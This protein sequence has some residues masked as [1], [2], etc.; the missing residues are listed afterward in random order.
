ML[1][2]AQMILAVS[3]FSIALAAISK[4]RVGVRVAVDATYCAGM[5]RLTT[6]L[7]LS[8]LPLLPTLAITNPANHSRGKE[9]QVVT[10]GSQHQQLDRHPAG[11]ERQSITSRMQ[12]SQ[13]LDLDRQDK[14]QIQREVVGLVAC[15]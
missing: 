12:P 15:G 6:R 4:F 13:P 2:I 10:N 7:E 3:F 8:R 14:K 1:V 9:D 5:S 11:Q